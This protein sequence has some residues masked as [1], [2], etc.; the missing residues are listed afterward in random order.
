MLV[1]LDLENKCDDGYVQITSNIIAIDGISNPTPPNYTD[2]NT[3]VTVFGNM[4]E[5]IYWEQGI[6]IVS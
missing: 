2:T 6:Y 4:G 1:N 5:Y 3:T